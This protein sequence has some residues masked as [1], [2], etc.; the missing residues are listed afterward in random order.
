MR[1][2]AAA[3]NRPGSAPGTAPGT[4]RPPRAACARA[5]PHGGAGL[6]PAGRGAR[7]R[8]RARGRSATHSLARSLSRGPLRLQA[9]PNRSP[10][11]ME[12]APGAAAEGSGVEFGSAEQN[13]VRVPSRLAMEVIYLECSQAACS[14]LF[15][16]QWC[17]CGRSFNRQK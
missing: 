9:E 17:L 11:T 15:L 1:G 8:D 5:Q 10:R 12:E 6:Q 16:T 7:A 4:A 13:I 14:H 3:W 2:W